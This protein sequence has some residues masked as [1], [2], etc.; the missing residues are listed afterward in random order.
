[1]NGAFNMPG[2]L[3]N[4]R[5][6]DTDK[7]AQ[8]IFRQ[9]TKHFGL[10][11]VFMSVETVQIGERFEQGVEYALQLSD[12]FLPIIGNKWIASPDDSPARYQN[13]LDDL[14]EYEIS[15]A[16][17]RGLEVIPL[18][19]DGASMP[20]QTDLP[21]CLHALTQFTPVTLEPKNLWRQVNR[22]INRI[23]S[24]RTARETKR[25][26]LIHTLLRY[27]RDQHLALDFGIISLQPFNPSVNQLLGTVRLSDF[28]YKNVAAFVSLGCKVRG[29]AL[30]QPNLIEVEMTWQPPDNEMR[31]AEIADDLINF[32]RLAGYPNYQNLEIQKRDEEYAQSLSRRP[33]TRATPV[34]L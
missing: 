4:Y 22:L 19:V 23:Q 34:P 32:A 6:N 27:S 5:K 33:R 26:E 24:I 18:L 12:F 3:I 11:H 13:G 29:A 17:Q 31:A 10:N 2:I 7:Y 30:D 16:V 9:L 8:R 25:S 21:D 14:M 28:G 20:S 1:M 15:A